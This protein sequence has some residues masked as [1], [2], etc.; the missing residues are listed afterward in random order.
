MTP[1]II[2]QDS[3]ILIINKPFGLTVN[4]SDTTR[5]QPTLQNW[6]EKHI[7]QDTGKADDQG[8]FYQRGGIVHRLDKETSGV[9]VIAKT[10]SAFENLQK[11]FK[12]RTVL[13]SYLALVHGVVEPKSSTI[14]VPVGRLPWMRKRFGVLPGGRESETYYEVIDTYQTKVGKKEQLSFLRLL[15]KTGR[16]HQIRVHLKHIGYPVFS[17]LLYAGRKTARSDRKLLPRLFLHAFSLSFVHP[18]TNKQVLFE[19][20]L[21][22]ELANF[23]KKLD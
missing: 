15:P 11:Q 22:D 20:P 2:F 4:R 7:L 1:S 10:A 8:D 14:R 6:A 3:D 9:L 16:T 21:P 19:S 17:D 12:V 5:D 23:L 18:T 13:K